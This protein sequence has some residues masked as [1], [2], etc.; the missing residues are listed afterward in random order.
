VAWARDNQVDAV[1]FVTGDAGKIV[2]CGLLCPGLVV[3]RANNKEWVW[4]S[5]TPRDL[6][7]HFEEAMREC[8]RE[9]PLPAILT[10]IRD[11][12]KDG[13]AEARR[14]V[15]ALRPDQ[16]RRVGLELALR[17]LADRSTVDGRVACSFEGV[18][19]GDGLAPERQHE[20][21]RIAQEAVSNAVRHARPGT[22]GR[23]PVRTRHRRPPGVR[24]LQ[25]RSRRRRYGERWRAGGNAEC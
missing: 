5:A 24:V 25:Q 2:K 14:S 10:R 3:L 7:E 13:L 22:M 21:L 17:Q 23:T 8:K 16:T 6:K 15:M 11:L 9:S 1:A 4:D 18:L 20:L 19:T 12:A